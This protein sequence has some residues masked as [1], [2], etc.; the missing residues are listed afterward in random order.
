MQVPEVFMQ[1]LM[2]H[3]ETHLLL[4]QLGYEALVVCLIP[5]VSSCSLHR[6]L[7]P[8]KLSLTHHYYGGD[9]LPLFA[10]HDPY[11]SFTYLLFRC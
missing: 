2:Q 5:P 6:V 4:S 10:G 8:H 3:K 11:L 7:I 1:A 9:T